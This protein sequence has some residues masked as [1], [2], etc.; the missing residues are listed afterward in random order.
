MPHLY[1][2]KF[3]PNG[4]ASPLNLRCGITARNKYEAEEITRIK[5]F[6]VFGLRKMEIVAEDVDVSKL[7]PGHVLPNMGNPAV[8]GVWFPI[9]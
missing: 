1:W 2:V 4:K 3:K 9:I 6:S 8:I 7:D 5:A